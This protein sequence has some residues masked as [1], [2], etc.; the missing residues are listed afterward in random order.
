MNALDLAARLFDSADEAIARTLDP[1][2]P[3]RYGVTIDLAGPRRVLIDRRDGGA[4]R[5][6]LRRQLAPP[7][8]AEFD[9]L[10]PRLDRLERIC[11]RSGGRL[12]DSLDQLDEIRPTPTTATAP[13]WPWLVLAA[14]AGL[15]PEIL[16]MRPGAR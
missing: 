13:L 14:V 16:I 1:L 4:T 5:T 12:L 7:L 3:G 10:A 8:A 15:I 11:R 2:G 9:H 6:V